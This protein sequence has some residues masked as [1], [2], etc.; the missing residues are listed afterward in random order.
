MPYPPHLWAVVRQSALIWLLLRAALFLLMWLE[1]GAAAALHPSAG[2]RLL[3]IGLTAVLVALE[4]RRTRALLL[5]ANLGVTERWFRAAALLAA[6][7]LDGV[8]QALLALG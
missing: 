6:A 8:A 7:V 5:T 2:A 4:R 1:A 3:L